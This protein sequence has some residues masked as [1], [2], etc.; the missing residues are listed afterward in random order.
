MKKE[1]RNN[2]KQKIKRKNENG[3]RKD[4]RKIHMSVRKKYKWKKTRK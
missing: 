4:E 3:R 1:R 2:C